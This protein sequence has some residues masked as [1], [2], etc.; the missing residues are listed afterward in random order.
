MKKYR[1]EKHLLIQIATAFCVL[2]AVLLKVHNNELNMG[3][4]FELDEN[5]QVSETFQTHLASQAFQQSHRDSQTEGTLSQDGTRTATSDISS[6]VK[7]A[8]DMA[9]KTSSDAQ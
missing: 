1:N 7:A 4:A 6:L 8:A 9:S 5:L 2:S 3:N